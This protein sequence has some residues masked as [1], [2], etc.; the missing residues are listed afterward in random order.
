MAY[1]IVFF[2]DVP[3]ELEDEYLMFRPEI[4]VD[5]HNETAHYMVTYKDGKFYCA[6][7]I[8]VESLINADTVP[9]LIVKITEDSALI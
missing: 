3:K 9:E 2:Q 5:E 4:D 8:F 7:F 1:P 6:R